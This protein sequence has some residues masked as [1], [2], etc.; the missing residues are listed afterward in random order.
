MIP[1]ML[2]FEALVINVLLQYLNNTEVKLQYN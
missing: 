1:K 2:R